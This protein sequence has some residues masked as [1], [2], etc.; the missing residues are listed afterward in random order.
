MAIQPKK[1]PSPQTV[2]TSPH[3]F[4]ETEIQ[5]LKELREKIGKLTL[6]LGHLMINKI[7]LEKTEQSL[8]N[9][10]VNLEKEEQTIAKSLSKKYGEGSIDLSSGTF[11]PSN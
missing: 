9:E 8:K 1:S 4:D 3:S 2:K 10:L 6:N 7:N 5:Q 11:T